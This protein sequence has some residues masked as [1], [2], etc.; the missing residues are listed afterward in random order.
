MDSPESVAFRR[1]FCTLFCRLYDP[2]AL[3]IELFSNG[4]ITNHGKDQITTTPNLLE[5]RV[6]FL[7]E[8]ERSIKQQPKNFDKVL[9]ALKAD[10]ALRELA[11]QLDEV[12]EE[13]KYLQGR[14]RSYSAPPSIPLMPSAAIKVR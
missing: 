8:L 14:P 2:T 9:E 7:N 11:L 1:Q 13:Q 12:R 10:A 6:L 4:V 5:K 3:A